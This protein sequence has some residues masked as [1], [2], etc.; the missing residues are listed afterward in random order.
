VERRLGLVYAVALR[1]TSG[2]AHRAQ[3]I[4][5]TVFTNLA[6]K[7]SSLARQP[8]IAGWLYRSAQF[9]RERCDADGMAAPNPGAGG[10]TP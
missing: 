4:A 10:P 6:R 8:V 3:D 7:A 5:Q 2:D 1:Q 9:C